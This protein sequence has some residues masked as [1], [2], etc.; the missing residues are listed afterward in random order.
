MCGSSTTESCRTPSPVIANVQEKKLLMPICHSYADWATVW[1]EWCTCPRGEYAL[2]S[3]AE[4]R[5]FSSRCVYEKGVGE[6]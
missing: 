4:A 3:W 2:P 6:P 5:E 1:W